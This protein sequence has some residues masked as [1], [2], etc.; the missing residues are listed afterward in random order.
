MKPERQE[1]F[2]A[3]IDSFEDDELRAL[4]ESLAM[5]HLHQKDIETIA[6]VMA[7]IV[8]LKMRSCGIH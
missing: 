7:D 5:A 4:F 2:E 1:A 8:R 6:H 3:A